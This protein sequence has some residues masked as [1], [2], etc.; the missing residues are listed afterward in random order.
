MNP[1]RNLH[2]AAYACLM[3]PGVAEKCAATRALA[4]AWSS[5]RLA[6]GA[7]AKP[8]S[9]AAPGRPARPE[10]VSPRRLRR[11]GL[12][13]LEGRAILLHA[14]AHIE[15]NAINL[16]LDAVYRFR[17]LPRGFYDD[18]VRVAAEEVYH[19]GL[20]AAHLGG[21]GHDYGDFPAHDGL[22]E[23]ARAT[24]DD[25]LARMA[26]VPRVLEARGLDVNPAMRARLVEVGDGEAAEILDIILRDE[27]GHV[28][29][30]NR[31][32][33]HLCRERGLDPW[34]TFAGLVRRHLKGGLRGPFLR[35][36]RLAAGFTEAEL[37]ALEQLA[38][39][40]TE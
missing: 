6:P 24:A 8:V 35:E 10:L 38:E 1:E 37:D 3:E 36:H 15:F 22:W 14:V 30:G 4:A 27:V 7:A 5:G 9:I 17:D 33:H 31:W 19:F 16:A 25:P 18:W 28:A 29:A 20:V 11:R 40:K 13:T 2:D 32:F 21:L 39:E 34:A 12:G 26:L 23:A